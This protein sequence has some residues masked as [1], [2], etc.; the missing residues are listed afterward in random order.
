MNL[1]LD[2]L[3][4]EKDGLK[5]NTDFRVG[6]LF[7]LLMQDNEM[8]DEDKILATFNLYFNNLPNN[9][10][11]AL[12]NQSDALQTIL[13]FFKCGE[14]EKEV[15]KSKKVG[16]KK[17]IYSFE[18]DDEYIYDAFLEQ[19]GIDLNEVKLHWWKFRAMFVGLNENVLFSKIMSYRQID[20][21]K[22]KD[23]EEKN[24]IK[25]L[26]EFYKLPDM[27]TQEQKENDFANA[28]W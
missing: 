16:K 4:T 24:R 3:P 10:E 18:F 5:I 14:E 27:R 21:G 12:K 25:K 11:K 7:E 26:K 15:M 2:K 20:L 13:W 1:L 22:I 19:Y 8:S 9:L 28:F 17:Q 6:I 23:K